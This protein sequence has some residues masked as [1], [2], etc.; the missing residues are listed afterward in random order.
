[1]NVLVYFPIVNRSNGGIFQYTYALLKTLGK[2]DENNYF[3]FTEKNEEIN[4]LILNNQRFRWINPDEAVESIWVKRWIRL[5]QFGLRI[6][7][8]I[9]INTQY[10]FLSPLDKVCKRYA[11]NVLHSPVQTI[12][13][14]CVPKMVTLHDV[15]ELH[16]PEFFTSG[17]RMWRA[18]N[19]K[20]SIDSADAVIVSYEHIRK[21]IVR[22]FDK[23]EEQI[24]VVL[25]E[26][27]NLWFE[28]YLNQP[29]KS[30]SDS[31]PQSMPYL[32]YPAAIWPHKNH[33]GLLK[34]LKIT[35]DK[36][37]RVKLLCTGHL[38]QHFENLKKVIAELELEEDVNFLG[39]VPD[40]ELFKLYRNAIGI[41]VPTLYEAGSFPL[42]EA[43]L[44]RIPVVCSNVTSLPETIGS[45]DYIFD[46]NDYHAIAEK[47]EKL[48]SSE[49]FR[50]E[51]IKN[52]EL[53]GTKLRDTGALEKI[54][55]IYARISYPN[56]NR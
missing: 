34:A 14:V 32:L 12:P 43:I 50:F 11:I 31:Y 17:E 3:L 56:L 41:V 33:E 6:L 26:M 44:M 19:Y 48:V 52:S 5:L 37:L 45:S 15:Q 9:G 7:K 46:P 55:Y 18:I 38:T 13:Q 51:N 25:M 1:M 49:E 22:F 53:Q 39:I 28:K 20:S 8:L 54:K 27:N 4:E 42:M 40:E 47:I 24:H 16:F 10:N 29:Q 36:G 30:N 35:K 2:D 23:A 21:D